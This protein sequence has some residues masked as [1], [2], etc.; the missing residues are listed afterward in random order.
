MNIR[1]GDVVATSDG[2]SLSKKNTSFK[3]LGGSMGNDLL[4][5]AVDDLDDTMCVLTNGFGL[6]WVHFD[7]RRVSVVR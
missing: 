7:S 6:V 2:W 5:V 3:A 4:V 1:P